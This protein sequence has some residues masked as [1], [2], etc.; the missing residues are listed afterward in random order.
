MKLLLAVLLIA[1]IPAGAAQQSGCG[2]LCG[3][4][5]LDPSA[6]SAVEA[7]VE[8]ALSTYSD[9]RVRKTPRSLRSRAG[10]PE[11]TVD[12]ISK[13]MEHSLGPI[14]DRPERADMRSELM[15]LLTPPALLN[16]DA[17]GAEILIQ[18]DSQI[19]RRLSPG[20]PRTRVSTIGTSTILAK[21]RSGR[22]TISE[23]HDR[24]RQYNETYT[25]RPADGALLV[26]REVQRP[27][28]KTLRLQAVYRRA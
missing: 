24:R 3:K 19:A 25:L 8:T 14:K 1:T 15:S 17:R 4:W 7:T 20:S 23:R 27:G 6:S 12:Q 11:D 13:E 2:L 26:T 10:L 16:L 21:W 5:E 9:P 22:L 18:G 28:L